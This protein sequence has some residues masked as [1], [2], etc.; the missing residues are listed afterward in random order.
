MSFHGGL[1]GILLAGAYV[2][3]RLRIPFL[4]LAD[5]G[6]VAAPI[7]F[8]LGRLANFVNDELWGRA[9]TVPWAMVFPNDRRP[10]RGTRR[11]STRPGSRESCCSP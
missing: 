1:I 2:T 8:F 9:T 3:R 6:A 7:G 10:C 4:T 5:I 11:S